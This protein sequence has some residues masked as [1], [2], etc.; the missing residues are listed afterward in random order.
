M[1]DMVIMLA[2][3]TWKVAYVI[4]LLEWM[5]YFDES[6]RSVSDMS[7]FRHLNL[8]RDNEERLS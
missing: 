2:V 1:I 6:V 5:M 7:L 4:L 8:Y 3:L